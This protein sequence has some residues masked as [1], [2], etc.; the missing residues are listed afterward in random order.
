LT[1]STEGLP[2]GDLNWFAD[3]KAKWEA[4]KDA[5]MAH[6]LALNEDQY[7]IPTGIKPVTNE[8][9]FGAFPNPGDNAITI[10]SSVELKSVRFFDVAGKLM[11]TIEMQNSFTKN[12]DIAD[13]NKGVYILKA[14]SVSG[15]NYTSKFVKK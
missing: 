15:E 12:I 11:K 13:F 2:L 7:A 3:K 9:I 8:S 6:I 10:R 4:E 1:A 14:E 5:I